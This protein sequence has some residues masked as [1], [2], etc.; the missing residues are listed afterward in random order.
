MTT[1]FD[2]LTNV[3]HETLAIDTCPVAVYEALYAAA[4]PAFLYESLQTDG[5]RGR[6]SFL[7]GAP[8]AVATLHG[9]AATIERSGA[10]Q[11]IDG[12]FTDTLRKLLADLPALP[13][14]APL[15]GGLVGFFAYDYARRIEHIPDNNADPLGMPDAMMMAPGELVVIDHIDKRTDILL[16]GPSATA[17]R[18]AHIEARI[19]EHAHKPILPTAP[20]ARAF[21]AP[22]PIGMKPTDAIRASMT[23]AEYESA[24]EKAKDHIRRGDIFQVVPS[25]RFSFDMPCS[26][27]RLYKALRITNPSPYMYFLDTDNFQIVGS[28]PEMVV[29]CTDRRARIRPL[30]GTRKRGGTPEEDTR[31]EADLRA[32]LKERAEHIMLVDLARNDLGRVCAYGSVQTSDLLDVERYARVMHIVSNVEG[33]LRPDC[34]AFDLIHAV[35]PAGTVSGAPKIRAMQ[36][37]DELENTRRGLYG[38]AI[39][40]IGANGNVDLCLAIRTIVVKDGAGHIQAGAGVVADSDPTREY[41]ETLNKAAG[42]LRALQLVEH[43][44]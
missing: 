32:D 26:A 21:H 31:L 29:Q 14:I 22:P 9:D 11:P 35:F 20:G 23:Q 1:A 28:S 36:I 8:L 4:R 6:Y 18:L 43:V 42:V 44:E 2:T 40:Y 15:A 25:Q 10:T 5:E 27:L 41:E 39:G 13:D 38:G 33:T 16:V 12:P 19:R 34:D 37:I 17:A 24:V 30:A 3:L 7:G